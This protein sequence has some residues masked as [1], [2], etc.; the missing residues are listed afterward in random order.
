ME[1]FLPNL[2]EAGKFFAFT[3]VEML[4]LFVGISFL[5]G[6][7]NEF[8]TPAKVERWLSSRHGRGYFIGAGLGALTPFC[9]CSTIPIMLGLMKARA[10]F[11]PTMS[12]LVASPL[13]NPVIIALFVTAIGPWRAA[14]YAAMALAMAM[15]TGL[16]L[17]KLGFARQVRPEALSGQVEAG[18]GCAAEPAPAQEA[19]CPTGPAPLQTAPLQ[20]APLQA[21]PQGL[22]SLQAAPA[23]ACCASGEATA[24]PESRW[25]RIFKEAVS[26]FK[27]FLPYVALGVAV[28]ALAHGFVPADF[29]ARWAGP[30]NPLAVPAAALIGVPLYV[31]ASTMIPIAMSLMAKGLSLGTM[32][33]LVIGG[34][35]ASLPEVIMLK[36]I[37][38]LPLLAAFLLAIFSMA[39]I[40][41]FIFNL[42]G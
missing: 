10:G 25:L 12:F 39:V 29:V 35:G 4:I 18:C 21:A 27:T 41:G 20:T 40:A 34:A 13:L 14:F 26:Q 2:I 31:R 6:V 17:E 33:A 37:F 22:D 24:L 42:L 1:S 19:C 15:G 9:S 36:G 30:D 32:M 28:G 38:R 11:G 16:V 7:L 23:A 5:V 8:I 3:M